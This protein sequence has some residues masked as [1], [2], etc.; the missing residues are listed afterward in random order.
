MASDSVKKAPPL[1]LQPLF[2]ILNRAE[3]GTVVSA[4]PDGSQL[5]STPMSAHGPQGG[6]ICIVCLHPPPAHTHTDLH[7]CFAFAHLDQVQFSCSFTLQHVNRNHDKQFPV[8]TAAH[9]V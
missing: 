9:T 7:L 8:A 5:P 1:P 6:N 2:F 3:T 4:V